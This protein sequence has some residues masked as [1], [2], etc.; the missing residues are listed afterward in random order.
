MWGDV[1]IS[2]HITVKKCFKKFNDETGCKSQEWVFSEIMS[3]FFSFICAGPDWFCNQRSN[4]I[5]PENEK[6]DKIVI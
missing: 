5:P 3:I 1:A 2:E 6:W 4:N